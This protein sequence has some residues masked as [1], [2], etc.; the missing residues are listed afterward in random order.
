M[1]V[2]FNLKSS[3][4]GK[5]GTM[6]SVVHGSNAVINVED[7]TIQ[8]MDNGLV[9]RDQ[10]PEEILASLLIDLGIKGDDA[11]L[12]AFQDLVNSLKQSPIQN[13]DELEERVKESAIFRLLGKAENVLGPLSSAVNLGKSIMEF[14]P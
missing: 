5:V 2:I 14:F 13:E 10:K 12:N 9:E 6:A 3:N 11:K 8:E 1:A 7:T 4:V